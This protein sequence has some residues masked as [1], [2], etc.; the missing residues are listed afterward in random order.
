M[1][2]DQP[3]VDSVRRPTAKVGPDAIAT[4]GVVVEALRLA[5]DASDANGI[6]TGILD[7]LASLVDHDAAYT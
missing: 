7:G 4:A 2:L 3:A 5:T 1:A 6:L